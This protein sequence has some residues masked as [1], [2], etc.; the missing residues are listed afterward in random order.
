MNKDFAESVHTFC[1]QVFKKFLE[2]FSG[3]EVNSDEC[4]HEVV[5]KYLFPD[6]VPGKAVKKK[7]LDKK[8]KKKLS[9]YTYF[10]KDNKDAFNKEIEE[11]EKETGEKIKYL[12][13][14]SKKWK[15]LTDDERE[16][17]NVKASEFNE[18][19]NEE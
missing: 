3:K 12:S 16:E 19:N 2:D 1:D 11:N 18:Q 17:W 5:M 10:G 6:Y 9:G 13:L 15:A 8:K 7:V 4:S 14:V